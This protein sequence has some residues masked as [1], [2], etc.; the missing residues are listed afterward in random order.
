MTGTRPSQWIGDAAGTLTMIWESSFGDV[1]DVHVVSP[2]PQWRL[3]KFNPVKLLITSPMHSRH[4]PVDAGTSPSLTTIWKPELCT[5]YSTQAIINYRFL[6]PYQAKVSTSKSFNDVYFIAVAAR[7]RLQS[8]L[9]VLEHLQYFLDCLINTPLS[10]SKQCWFM[11][12]IHAA[13]T[14]IYQQITIMDISVKLKLI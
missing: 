2:T 8:L 11:E 14:S 7:F 3:E 9:K 12:D 4:V 13:H 6:C 10:P 1:A 5:K